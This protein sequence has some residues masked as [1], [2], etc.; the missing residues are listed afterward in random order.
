MLS[1]Y[2]VQPCVCGCVSLDT[3]ESNETLEGHQGK[4]VTV[5]EDLV[6]VLP[7]C[8]SGEVDL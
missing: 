4:T 2:P 8:Q 1:S 3:L 7:R 6:L 5:L